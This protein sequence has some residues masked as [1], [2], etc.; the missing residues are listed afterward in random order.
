MGGF[1][2]FV[3][4]ARCVFCLVC[5]CVLVCFISVSVE[6]LLLFVMLRVIVVIARL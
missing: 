2:C 5:L 4:V 3:D 6:C 1:A